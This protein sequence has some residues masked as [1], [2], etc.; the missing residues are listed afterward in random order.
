MIKVKY[1][2][3]DY[4]WDTKH[5]YEGTPEEIKKFMEIEENE[6]IEDSAVLINEVKNED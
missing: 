2:Q 5:I 4:K 3:I 1:T 6:D